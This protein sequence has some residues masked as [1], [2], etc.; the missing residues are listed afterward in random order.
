MWFARGLSTAAEVAVT[1]GV[2]VL[3]LVVH[4]LWWTNRQAT[5]GAAR[6]VQAL[7][8]E[9]EGERKPPAG[10]EVREAEP[11]PKA[12]TD[13]GAA[14]DRGPEPPRWDR[15]YAVLRI[16]RLGVVAPVAEGIGKR[17]VLDKGYVGHYPGT[18]Q[19]GRA[20]NFAVAGHRNSHGEP[21]RHIDRLRPGD[22]VEVETREGVY[23]YAVDRTLPRTLPGE[24]GVIDPVPRSSVRPAAG[25]RAAGNYLTMT[26]CTPEFSSRFRLVVWGRL[27]AVRPR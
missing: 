2:V 25:Y 12:D 19:P 26:T 24:T 14:P 13:A 22:T 21:F 3:L 10:E 8:R 16:P 9:W 11:T 5:Q 27:A 7:E 17:G 15:A 18:V 6:Q 4:Q 20:G 1:L 23:V